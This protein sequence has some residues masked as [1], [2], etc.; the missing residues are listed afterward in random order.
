MDLEFNLLRLK[1][2]YGDLGLS[3]ARDGGARQPAPDLLK[4]DPSQ[5]IRTDLENDGFCRE[6][7]G[8]F[9]IA[10]RA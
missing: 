4:A 10:G 7:T 3:R 9:I 8:T 5:T 6:Q 2:W 1:R